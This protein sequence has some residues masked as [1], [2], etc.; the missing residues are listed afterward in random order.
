[1]KLLPLTI[2]A[3]LQMPRWT[4]LFSDAIAVSSIGVVSGGT[5]TL[6]C[7]A[8]HGVAIGSN[9]AVSITDALVPNPITAATVL[10]DG[11]VSITTQYPHNLSGSPDPTRF[12]AFSDVARLSGFSSALANGIRDLVS[13]PTESTVVYRPGGT[14]TPGA[15]TL[16]GNEVLNEN[17]EFEVTGWH[18]V[19]AATSTT[20]TF[21]APVGVTR[22]YTVTA[23][24]VVRNMRVYGAIDGEAAV[25][26]LTVDGDL[27][28]LDK[29]HLF[30]LPHPVKSK[31]KF[32]LTSASPGNDYR[33][34]VS[35]GFTLLVFLPSANAAAHV[36]AIDLC[37]GE[38]FKA[39]M[40]SF[41]GLRILRSEVCAPGTYVATFQSHQGGMHKNNA[42]YAH[43][44]VFDAPFQIANAD[45]LSPVAWT[46]LDDAALA[47]GTVPESIYPEG[48]GPWSE[49]DI[50]GIIHTGH[51]S[52]LSGTYD[53]E[54]A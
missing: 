5:V 42:V 25:R 54:T 27:L 16:T 31:G 22:S 8:A 44:Y 43:E 9:I 45:A 46:L 4:S 20:L 52:P 26:Q 48:S 39:V 14:M 28:A 17:L 12:K 10:A 2:H 38:V 41:F 30:V 32:N 53:M 11:T 6:T 3:A 36:E 18:R 37:Q 21:P 23:P 49:I 29:G 1:M 24:T 34:E 33:Q 51:A 15:I 13:T 50:T 47:N 40:R 7:S 35:D 19:T